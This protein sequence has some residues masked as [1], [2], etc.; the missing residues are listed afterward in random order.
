MDHP[1]NK[2][3]EDQWVMLVAFDTTNSGPILANWYRV[4]GVGRDLPR[5]TSP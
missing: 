5:P 2:V 1:I 4:V 3:K